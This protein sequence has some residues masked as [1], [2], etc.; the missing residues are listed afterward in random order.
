M[1][2]LLKYDFIYLKRTGKFIIF[3]AVAIVFAL[4]SPLAAMY[5]NELLAFLADSAGEP[6]FQLP[7]PVVSD[8]YA[9]YLS[10]LYEIFLIVTIFISVSVFMR[11][12][13]KGVLPLVL[14]KPINRVKYLLSKYISLFT[15][16]LVSLLI[17]D[18][19]FAYSTWVLFGEVNLL[20]VLY[21]TALFML[22]ILMIFS[23][24]LFFSMITKNYATA[25]ILT[26]VAYIVISIFGSLEYGILDYLPGRLLVRI[27]EFTFLLTI[28]STAWITIIVTILFITLFGWLGIRSFKN[29][30]L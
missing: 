15:V 13:N 24:S 8:S 21:L 14:S 3:P 22:Y 2:K 23:F 17:S 1:I 30:D 18:I 29:Y 4:L 5:V 25:S 10:N 28:D 12:K 6:L 26:F 11:D 7:D 9:Q 19:V 27:T 16:I 20:I